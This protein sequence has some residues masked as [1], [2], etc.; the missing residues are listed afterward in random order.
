MEFFSLTPLWW[1]L[2]IIPLA[3]GYGFSLVDR[4]AKFKVL[5]IACRII[6]IVLLVLTL[7]RPF[8]KNETKSVHVSFLIDGSESVDPESMKT[9]LAHIESSIASLDS[10][11][12]HSLFIFASEL[13]E[14][15][16][17]EIKKFITSC[18]QGVSDAKFRSSTDLTQSLL[19]ARMSFPAGKSRRLVVYTDAAATTSGLE[20]ALA[21]LKSEQVDL[22]LNQIEPLQ[23]PEAALVSI[24]PASLNA[25][26]N[27][28]LRIKV[29]SQSNSDMAGRLRILHKGVAVTEQTIQLEANTPTISYADVEMT[30][31]GASH[32]QAE[33]IPERDYFPLN[34]KLSTT[35]KVKGQPRVL[36]IHS[37]REKLRSFSR[38][39]A[40]QGIDM[41]V[42]GARGLPE[43]LEAMLAFDAII[44]ADVP[45]TDLMV[46]QMENLKRYVSEFGGGLAMMGSENSY[47]LGGYY[48]TPIEEVIPLTSRFEKEKQK[49][50][51]SMVLVLDKSGSMEGTPMELTRQAAKAAAELL[52]SRDQIAVIGFDS[53]PMVVCE[54]TSAGN[55]VQI[56]NAIDTLGASGGTNM[57]PAMVQGYDMLQ[58]ANTKIKHMIVMTDGHT[59]EADHI[60]LTQQM[61]DSG[62]TVSSVAMGSGADA[63]LLEE[64]ANYGKGRFYQ[65]DDPA[66][67]PQ[68]FTKETM[69]ASKSAIKEDLYGSVITGD[70][71]VLT[72]YEQTEL[73]MVLGFVMTKSK[74][75]SE[76]LL[77]TE[78]GDPLLAINRFG[79]GTGLAYT[80]DLTERWGGEWLA[81]SGAS[82]FW[83]QVIRGILKTED[84]TGLSIVQDITDDQWRIEASHK[85]LNG[86]PV[87]GSQWTAEAINQDGKKLAMDISQ[88]GIGKYAGSLDLHGSNAVAL[89][90]QD[91]DHDK[92]KTLYWQRS[93]PAEY[94]L[95]GKTP[96]ILT[97][98]PSIN[99]ESIREN[100]IK[101]Y[102]HQN[103]TP[104]FALLAFAFL[105][106]GVVLRRV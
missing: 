64:I 16:P 63:N 38:A 89:R 100:L 51:L 81:W 105:I 44:L 73:P 90:I 58:A 27:E 83:A 103:I 97:S 11:D 53:N 28:I 52:G 18:E 48:K 7:C 6:G 4:P 19:S 61:V 25:F 26:Q 24:E 32:W 87:N 72:G 84:D 65:T 5:S 34:N 71:P 56:M 35:I 68:I 76:L 2:V 21:T 80:S 22:F 92:V 102:R 106:T 20:D 12:S 99:A 82:K 98:L 54:M 66:N 46:N 59:Q 67:V 95:G 15:Q 94:Q 62:I 74:P 70:H 79:L 50:S 78:T 69:Q 41:D 33:L 3:I 47:G 37:Q 14:M 42:R 45:A 86:A 104:Y 57:F 10:G 60:S 101:H 17:D 55:K 49:P 40:K 23:K 30:S 43:S 85:G 77:V 88:T 1:L 39:M 29:T 36:V 9:A 96:E 93:Y 31:S 75:T 8:I 13:K 91:T